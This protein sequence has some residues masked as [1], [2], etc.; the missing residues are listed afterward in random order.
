[1]KKLKSFL[2]I[3]CLSFL[4]YYAIYP[5]L[6]SQIQKLPLSSAVFGPPK[7]SVSAKDYALKPGVEYIPVI[8]AHKVN[9]LPFPLLSS[10]KTHQFGRKKIENRKKGIYDFPENFV[11]IL[12]NARVIGKEGI[13]ITED[14]RVIKET[15]LNFHDTSYEQHWLFKK[16]SLPRLKKTHERIAIISADSPDWYFHWMCDL[17]PKLEILRLSGV[18]YDKIYL[19]KLTKQFQKDTLA[20]LGISSSEVVVGTKRTH[21][22]ADELIIPSLPGHPTTVP[23]WVIHFLREKFLHK[24]LEINGE[25]KEKRIY[26]SRKQTNWHRLINEDEVFAY[27]KEKGFEEV[28][29][30]NLSITEQATLF[31]NSSLIVAPHGAGLTNLVFASP[32][33]KIIEF[34]H[35]DWI[36]ECYWE[37]SQQIQLKHEVIVGTAIPE[38]PFWNDFVFKLIDKPTFDYSV[39]LKEV[40][41][42]IEA[43][44]QE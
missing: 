2:I 44:L 3:I 11:L 42:R 9:M 29:I 25:E 37:I 26:I 10:S 39:S 5:I 30:E 24:T 35:P 20:I 8:P 15:C 27:L 22:K 28:L 4:L 34:F 12:P 31:A 17:L 38:P 1:M 41:K 43:T 14:D 7:N 40:K 19:P 13:V 16:L 32:G 23:L 18:S 33:T 21:L 36:C 6:V